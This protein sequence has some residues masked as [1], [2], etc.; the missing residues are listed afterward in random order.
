MLAGDVSGP[1]RPSP[2]GS[3]EADPT[4]AELCLAL[5]GALRALARAGSGRPA[6]REI[7]RRHR[8]APRHAAT[9]AY[10]ALSGPMGVSALA[11]RLGVARTTASLL[12]AELAEAGLVDRREDVD[13]HRRTMV[14]VSQDS[15]SEVRQTIEARLAPLRRAAER[16][17]P[18]RVAE[19]TAG[20]VVL[21][22]ELGGES[23]GGT[24]VE[25][26]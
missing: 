4:V 14:A 15:R 7:L 1:G 9:L 26:L 18:A 5:F 11:A 24:R 2:P 21:A 17:G 22:E 3:F 6:A 25:T 10:L 20:L 13:D 23:C 8:L 19:L 12:V 16:L